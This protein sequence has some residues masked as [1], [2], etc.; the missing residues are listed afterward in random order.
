MGSGGSLGAECIESIA[1]NT[2]L[3]G[4]SV[5]CEWR[6]EIWM[7]PEIFFF[8]NNNLIEIQSTYH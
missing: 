6:W 7:A 1:G 3:G 4:M 8:I 5:G 2:C